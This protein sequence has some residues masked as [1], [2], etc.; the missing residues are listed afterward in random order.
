MQVHWFTPL[1][2]LV[3]SIWRED[4]D[5]INSR[6]RRKASIRKVLRELAQN[7]QPPKRII[8]G[9]TELLTGADFVEQLTL[10]GKK[11]GLGNVGPTPAQ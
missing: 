3:M 8:Y 6:S 10:L 5:G 1:G 4:T 2:I 7:Q 11:M 9:T